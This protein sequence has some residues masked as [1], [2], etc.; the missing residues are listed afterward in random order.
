MSALRRFCAHF[1]QDQGLRGGLLHW[2]WEILY[3]M[4]QCHRYAEKL[5][6]NRRVSH[7]LVN[8]QKQ[9]VAILLVIAILAGHFHANPEQI[10]CNPSIEWRPWKCVTTLDRCESLWLNYKTFRKFRYQNFLLCWIDAVPTLKLSI[11]SS[12]LLQ[13]NK[14]AVWQRCRQVR[15]P[16]PKCVGQCEGGS[17]SRAKDGK[18]LNNKS[19][20][21]LYLNFCSLGR[22]K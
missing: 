15:F 3:L 12:S 5:V 7:L 4:F 13:L 2:N 11:F 6:G 18:T 16:S 14:G 21:L 8:P 9:L 20:V 1:S 17:S 19:S 10:F 22:V